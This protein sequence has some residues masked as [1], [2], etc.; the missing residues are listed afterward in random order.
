MI[1]PQMKMWIDSAPYEVLL[2]R[3]RFSPSGDPFFQGE[4][5]EYY[6]K[7]IAERRASV[8]DAEHVRASKAVGWER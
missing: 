8:G 1:D 4:T 7:I 5:G 3:W 6:K 2:R